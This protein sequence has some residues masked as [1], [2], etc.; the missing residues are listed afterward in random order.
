VL[1]HGAGANCEAKILVNV[2]TGLCAA[3][4]FVLRIDL[5]FRQKRPTGPPMPAGRAAD[6]AVC[7]KRRLRCGRSR[8][9]GLSSEATRMA[10]E[11]RR[12]SRRRIRVLPMLCC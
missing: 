1:A 9:G 7:G 2:S 4:F 10:A 6:L 12:C 3:G 8:R 11:W 5:P